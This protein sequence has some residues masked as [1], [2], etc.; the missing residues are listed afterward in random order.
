[1]LRNFR[2]VFKSNKAPMGVIMMVVLLGMVAYLAPSRGGNLEAPDN[3]LARVYGRDIM[4][5]DLDR[6]MSDMAR[7]LGKNANLEAMAPFLKTQAMSMLVRDK[8]MEEL[9]ERHGIL[10]TDAEVKTALEAQ[11]RQIGF[12]GED[13]Q[14]RPSN[15]INDMLRERGWSLKQLEVTINTTLA[16]QKLFQQAAAQVPVDS[17]WVDLENRVRG[18]KISFE[19]VTQAPDA[20]VADPDPSTLEA[21]YKASGA[22]FQ[23][24]PRRVIDFVALTPAA[25]GVAPADDAAVKAVYDSRKGQF[26]EMR[27]SHIL[28]KAETDAEVL[29]AMK[30]AEELRPKL[31]AGQDFAKTAESLSQDPTA[32]AN[33]GDLG[34]FSSGTMQKP[35]EMAAMALK[36]GEISQPVRTS[37]G[38]HLIRLE[39]RREK[40]FEQVKEQLRAQLTRERFATKAKD[41]LEQLRKRAGDRG[42]LKAAA[43]NLGLKVQTS[44]AFSEE[45]G[46]VIDGLPGSQELTGDAFRLEV[47]QVSKVRQAQEAFVVFRVQEERPIGVPPLA[48]IKGQV[49]AAWKLE[50]ARRLALAKANDALKGGALQA[51]GVPE[52]KEAVT[53]S[54]LGE[55]GKHPAIRKALLDTPAGSL[56]PV[57]WTPDGKLWVAR[58]KAR[59]P[60]EPLSFAARKTLIEQIQMDVAQKFLSTE[61]Q[62]LERE[63]DLRPGFSS[64]YG[65]FNGI[66]RNRE[67]LGTGVDGVPDLGGLDD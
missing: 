44:P 55:L 29:E 25:L 67:A 24:G 48:E 59:V 13:N 51:L 11:L 66:W 16:K 53:I 65:R 31:L 43:K 18:E 10:V 9:A 1:M 47:G 21:F 42:D 38:I 61:V 39:G 28:F 37:F 19:A 56:T 5:R 14:L 2:T 15:E 45:S 23:S 27:A 41:R 17:E 34:W 58:I 26:S 3:V 46:A 8:L 33:K 7:R 30:K 20:K 32:K 49:V 50:E 36:E 57:L 40:P 52:A 62:S 35:F 22:R 6:S 12:V 60:A 54:S 63:G 64:F 4:R